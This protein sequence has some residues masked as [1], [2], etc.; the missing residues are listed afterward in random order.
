[1]RTLWQGQ[2]NFYRRGEILLATYEERCDQVRSEV[3]QLSNFKRLV[4][5]YWFVYSVACIE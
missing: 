4:P 5:K 2:D 1:M 3:L